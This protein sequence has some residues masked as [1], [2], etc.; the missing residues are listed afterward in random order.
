[1]TEKQAQA[2]TQ[3]LEFL[4]LVGRTLVTNRAI[5]K[6]RMEAVQAIRDAISDNGSK[7]QA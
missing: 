3:A 2:L 1:M 5:E 4:E 7:E 6:K